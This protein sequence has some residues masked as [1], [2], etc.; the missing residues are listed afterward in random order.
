MPGRS[1]MEPRGRN[2]LVL[3]RIVFYMRRNEVF[4]LQ[5]VGLCGEFCALKYF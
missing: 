5:E 4:L 1:W 2:N 3:A